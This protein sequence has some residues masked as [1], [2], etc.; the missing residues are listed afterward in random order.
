LDWL[1]ETTTQFGEAFIMRLLG[2]AKDSGVR[3]K[4]H[5]L[6]CDRAVK[7]IGAGWTGGGES[8]DSFR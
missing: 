3:L 5:V 4:A 7:L 1:A 8:E 6:G 2:L